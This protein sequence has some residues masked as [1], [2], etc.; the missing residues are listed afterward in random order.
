MVPDR[1]MA[2][3]ALAFGSGK[4]AKCAKVPKV[5]KTEP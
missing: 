3:E 5:K 2:V 1:G 4:V